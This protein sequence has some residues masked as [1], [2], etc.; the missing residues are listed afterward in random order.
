MYITG[1][2]ATSRL[3]ILIIAGALVL[4]VIGV[5]IYR[6]IYKG[7]IN[8][9]L[10]GEN[11]KRIIDPKDF[12]IISFIIVILAVLIISA[13]KMNNLY[14]SV[15][16]LSNQINSQSSL[17]T[18]LRGQIGDL[19]D[20]FDEYLH[21]QKLVNSYHY[22]VVDI[23]D[24][25]KIVY[26]IE[27]TLNEKEVDSDIKLVLQ[28]GDTEMIT[29][30]T[31]TS[32]NYIAYVSLD[33]E[34]DYDI[35]VMEEGSTI[36]QESLGT[37]EVLNDFGG[38]F[39]LDVSGGGDSSGFEFNFEIE[40]SYIGSNALLIDSVS[41]EVYYD[42]VLI[43][44]VVATEANYTSQDFEYF[45]MITEAEISLDD[46]GFEDKIRFKI[47]IVDNSGAIFTKDFIF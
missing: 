13:T 16:N 41:L 17:I 26:K 21:L 11:R 22:T 34:S 19:E 20:N 47:T 45:H 3:L 28:S 27:F 32:L 46:P 4:V 43:D 23:T 6:S 38:R 5:L 37:L 14:Y 9:A 42:D 39:D 8:K 40:N 12:S 10:N 15:N 1:A 2:F 31:S 44:T 35:F 25:G 30:L 33:D 18:S 7:N 36:K 24:E 29:D